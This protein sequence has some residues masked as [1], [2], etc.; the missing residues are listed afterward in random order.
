MAEELESNPKV[1]LLGE[2]VGLYNGAYEITRD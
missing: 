2:E 1:F